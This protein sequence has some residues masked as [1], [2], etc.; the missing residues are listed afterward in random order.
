MDTK[1]ALIMFCERCEIP[2]NLKQFEYDV[3]FVWY[4]FQCLNCSR[5][6]LISISIHTQFDQAL[7][8]DNCVYSQAGREVF[9]GTDDRNRD[10]PQH[11]R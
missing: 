2:M 9:A 8:L 11:G 5:E 1:N 7:T 4:S 6:R 3:E 10:D